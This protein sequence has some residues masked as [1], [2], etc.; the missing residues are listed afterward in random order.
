MGASA[1][2]ACDDDDDDDDDD[3]DT[4]HTPHP[5]PL[6]QGEDKTGIRGGFHGSVGPIFNISFI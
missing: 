6:F 3:N 5:P 1:R 2:S 4:D